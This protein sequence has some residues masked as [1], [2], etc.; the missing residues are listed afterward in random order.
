V[1]AALETGL[2]ADGKTVVQYR[3]NEFFAR[4]N[5]RVS[6]LTRSGWRDYALR[7]YSDGKGEWEYRC[8]AFDGV[9]PNVKADL[10]KNCG[11]GVRI[12]FD[13]VSVKQLKKFN[14]P[15]G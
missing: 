3:L 7:F 12:F 10:I 4:Q 8:S 15:W 13:K 2:S 9:F 6:D 5:V 14:L 11:T 1:V